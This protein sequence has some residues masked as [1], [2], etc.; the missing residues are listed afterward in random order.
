[1]V[2]PVKLQLGLGL[3]FIFRN[4]EEY[5]TGPTS[6]PKSAHDGALMAHCIPYGILGILTNE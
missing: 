5:E 6:E 1:M 2:R 3:G 4:P